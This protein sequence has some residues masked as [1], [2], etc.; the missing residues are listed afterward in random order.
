MS[1][2]FSV[3]DADGRIVHLPADAGR[4]LAQAVYMSGLWD[5]PA[6]CSGLGR[7]GRCRMRFLSAPPPPDAEECR[8]LAESEIA[9]GWR[10]GCRHPAVAGVRLVI[11]ARAAAEIPHDIRAEGPELLLAVDLGTTSLQ[12]AACDGEGEVAHG[13]GLNPQ[14]GAGSEVMSRLS[15][16]RGAQGAASLRTL[17][18]DRL[19]HVVAGLPGRVTHMAV[20]GNP[21]MTHII[22]GAPVDGLCAAPYALHERGGREV[23]L[24]PDL[25]PTYI[26]P[27][28]APFVGGDLSAGVA[29]LIAGDANVHFPFV[30]SDMGTNGEFVLALSPD[31][32]LAASVPL[33]PALE[34]IGLRF[35]TVAAPGAVVGFALAPDGLRAQCL[36]GGEADRALG[37]TGTGYVSL[38]ALLRSVGVLDA[39]GAFAAGETP[40]A[41][42]IV[43][44]IT[45]EGGEPALALPGGMHL[46]ASDVEEVLK[47]KAA[48]NFALAR[49]L[50]VAGLGAHELAALYLAGAMGEHVSTQALDVLGFLP[51][52]LSARVRTVGNTS[53]EGA[54]LVLRSDRARSF[55]EAL[56]GRTRLVE[57]A[58]DAGFGRHFL[59]CM[60]FDYIPA[61]MTREGDSA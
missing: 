23:R 19:R 55:A 35:G 22:L 4:T 56:P 2:T 13:S 17:V 44:R 14:M 58:E 36:G 25:P 54:A 52:G 3:Q 61:S 11:P 43:S 26:L 18:L 37:I 12:W 60:T 24:A 40:L 41:R 30:L 34:G 46:A 39:S 33:G 48:F 8:T 28:I 50:A 59:A 31:E 45:R 47:V 16:A 15:V 57:L 32:F 1:G 10:L 51:P 49:L 53:L 29:A 38:L 6:L 9:E 5:A 42:R 21:A 27:Q 20:A 7:C